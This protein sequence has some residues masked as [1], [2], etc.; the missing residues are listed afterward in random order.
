MTGCGS[1]VHE[2]WVEDNFHHFGVTIRSADGVVTDVEGK[3]LRYPWST[4]AEAGS[5]LRALIGEPLQYRAADIATRLPRQLQ[6]T[7]LFEVALLTIAHAATGR[8]AV[9]YDVSV[10]LSEQ[11]PKRF[12]STTLRNETTVLELEVSGTEIIAPAALSARDLYKGFHSWL[13]SLPDDEAEAMWITRRTC[14]LAAGAASYRR[15]ENPDGL[16]LGEVCHTFQPA[17]RFRA[18]FMSG[19]VIDISDPQSRLRQSREGD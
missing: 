1:G 16:G 12:F 18:H 10:S 11:D 2:G 8:G 15:T 17:Q 14:W 9:R 13:R 4:C 5:P 19:S 6:C 3:T 7:H